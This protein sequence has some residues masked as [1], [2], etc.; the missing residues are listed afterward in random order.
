MVEICKIACLQHTKCVAFHFSSEDR[1]CALKDFRGTA[2]T[3]TTRSYYAKRFRAF[4]MEPPGACAPH[5][6]TNTTATPAA[7]CSPATFVAVGA[8]FVQDKTG[9][10]QLLS[11]VTDISTCEDACAR[12]S[13]CAAFHASLSQEV[14]VLKSVP[15][16][17]A[18]LQLTPPTKEEF[19][20]YNRVGGPCGTDTTAPGR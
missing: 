8:G 20:A 13:N 9:T 15:A 14:C 6:S 2:A 7:G 5:P 11:G 16:D 18:T 1:I 4:N 17:S 19:V 12:L 3:L 10:L